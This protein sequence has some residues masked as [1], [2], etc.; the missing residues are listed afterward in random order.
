MNTIIVEIPKYLRKVKLSEARKAK[1]YEAG[2]AAPKA[3]RYHDR[4]RFD[5]QIHGTRSFLTDL[6]TGEKVIANPRAAGTPR[7]I[8]INGQKLYNGE[9]HKHIRNKVLS[10]IKQQYAPYINQLDV[11]TEFPLMIEMEVHDIIREPSSNS[12]WDL[13]NRSWPYIK[14]FQDCLTGNKDKDGNLRNKQ[15]IP[16]DHILFITQSPVPKFIPIEDEDERKLVF[17][18]K[19]EDDKRIIKSKVFIKELKILGHEIS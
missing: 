18:I 13:D 6:E 19:K 9:M 2:K 7:Y 11:I 10:E 5:Y 12:L 4:K 8:A 14:A 1:Y 3:K 15:I 17:R 16:D